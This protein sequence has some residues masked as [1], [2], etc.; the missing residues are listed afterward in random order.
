[1]LIVIGIWAYF[2]NKNSADYYT[3]SGKIPWWLS[4]ISHHVA[5]YSGAV[6]V[7]Y[8]GLAYTHGVS[9]Y[10]WWALTIAISMLATLKIF[11]VRWV[12]LRQKFN[13]Q[14]PL[15]YLATRY[16]VP[17]QQVM[18]W[19]GVILKL[20][21]LGAKWAAIAIL[22][23]VFTGIPIAYGILFSGLVS[24]VY[25][26][27]GGLWAVIITDFIQFI[28]Q[29]G[30]GIAMFLAVISRLGGWSSIF[31][32][33]EKLPEGNSQPFNHPYTIG[34]ALAFLLINTFSYNGGTWSLATKYISSTDEKTVKKAARLSSILYL[35]WP[36]IL[37]FP[38][39]AAPVILPNLANPTESY[40]LL[41]L[42]LLPAGLVGL[43]LASM[44]AATM[45]MAAGDVNTISA[46]IT[47]DILPSLSK[48][49]NSNHKGKSLRIAK[50][51]TFVFTLSTIIV[52]LQYESFGGVLGLIVSWFAALVGPISIPMLLGMI[53][54]FKTC[55]P[56]AAIS[57]IVGGLFTFVITKSIDVS[58]AVEISFPLLVSLIIFI[59]FGLFNRKKEV[60]VKINNMLDAISGEHAP[61]FKNDE[62]VIVEK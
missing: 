31:T 41:T 39:W 1:M 57:S 25:I 38:M 47:R 45:S 17:T 16:D 20:F 7:A 21:D 26:T 46:V 44:F 12:R 29:I 42:N 6:F 62:D 19:S 10:F 9:I 4:G 13:I 37:F 15:E 24:I 28:V 18:A 14:S 58:Y 27:I 5:G 51:V 48:K 11:P 2:K 23:K 36:L 30:A 54:L 55:G 22:L 33:W 8:A 40:G 49:F 61:S 3:A 52:A 34:F 59:L 60:S 53:P 35:I 32:L 56:K 50:I 43:V